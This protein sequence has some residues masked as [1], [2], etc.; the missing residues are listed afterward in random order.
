V[1]IRV[2]EQQQAPELVTMFVGRDSGDALL[3][4]KLSGH[5]EQGKARRRS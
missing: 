1:S 4:G 5:R 3:R 2:D